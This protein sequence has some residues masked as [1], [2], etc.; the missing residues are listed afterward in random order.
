MTVGELI[1]ELSKYDKN[2]RVLLYSHGTCSVADQD[3]ILGCHE[4]K[5]C[6][7]EDN[8]IEKVVSLYEY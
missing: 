2:Q 3:E 8:V 1:A 5:I 7:K 6:D 4:E